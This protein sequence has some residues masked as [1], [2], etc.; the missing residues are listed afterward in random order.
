M[1]VEQLNEHL[2]ALV[3]TLGVLATA[4]ATLG[5]ALARAIRQVRQ[6]VEGRDEQAELVRATVRSVERVTR[7]LDPETAKLIRERLAEEQGDYQPDIKA[8]VDEVRKR[9][10][11]A[12]KPDARK[13]EPKDGSASSGPSG[14][15]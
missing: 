13:L 6:A 12:R 9:E 8:V 10:P 7:G 5:A 1:D 15:A 14:G 4:A 2:T 11:D 3:V